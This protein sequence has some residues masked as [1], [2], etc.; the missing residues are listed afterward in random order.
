MNEKNDTPNNFSKSNQD[1]SFTTSESNGINNNNDKND[2]TTT[3]TTATIPIVKPVIQINIPY[4]ASAIILDTTNNLR[5]IFVGTDD[6][7]VIA[8]DFTGQVN[9]NS[10]Y[11]ANFTL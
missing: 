4:N 3:T 7:D 6:G 2:T 11:I 9:E 5:R 10:K 8:Y 1:F